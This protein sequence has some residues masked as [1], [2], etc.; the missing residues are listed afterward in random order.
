[1][2]KSVIEVVTFKLAQNVSADEFLESAKAVNNLLDQT[3]GF[4]RRHLSVALNRAHQGQCDRP[5]NRPGPR[6][7][8]RRNRHQYLHLRAVHFGRPTSRAVDL[9]CGDVHRSESRPGLARILPSRGPAGWF[10]KAYGNAPVP[11]S[12]RVLHDFLNQPVDPRDE[13]T[14]P[15]VSTPRGRAW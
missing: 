15:R 7:F 10:R 3:E 14:C 5:S 1:M 12:G 13:S 4:V 6:S 8:A 9:S 2:T 11:G